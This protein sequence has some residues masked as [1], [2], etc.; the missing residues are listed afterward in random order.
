MWPINYQRP[1]VVM[2]N[3]NYSCQVVKERKKKNVC[4]TRVQIFWQ[5]FSDE[6]CNFSQNIITTFFLIYTCFRSTALRQGKS[7]VV[8]MVLVVIQHSRFFAKENCQRI[9]MALVMLVRF[10]DH[11]NEL[12]IWFIFD[13]GSS[14]H[15]STTIF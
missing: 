11:K 13:F 9:M 5:C 7:L 8:N 1:L 12:L 14:N 15:F 10:G 2:F 6:C 4:V 3:S